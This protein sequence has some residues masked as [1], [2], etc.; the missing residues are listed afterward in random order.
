MMWN[1]IIKSYIK[2]FN[3]KEIIFYADIHNCF[4]NE[5]KTYSNILVIKTY[6]KFQT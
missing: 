6:L 5:K 3:N 2:S 4:Y 1:R